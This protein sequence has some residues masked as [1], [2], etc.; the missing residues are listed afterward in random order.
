MA[1]RIGQSAEAD[2]YRPGGDRYRGPIF[3]QQ[4]QPQ[5]YTSIP[6]GGFMGQ[7]QIGGQ[8]SINVFRKPPSPEE[9][10]DQEFRDRAEKYQQ[11]EAEFNLGQREAD[12]EELNRDRRI[13]EG[14][15]RN[16]AH[17]IKNRYY[18]L[19]GEPVSA[20]EMKA[21]SGKYLREYTTP[22]KVTPEQERTNSI[23]KSLRQFQ[24]NP[25]Q[26]LLGGG[27]NVRELLNYLNTANQLFK[28][29]GQEGNFMDSLFGSLQKSQGNVPR[30][31][32]QN[33]NDVR[34][35]QRQDLLRR[36]EEKRKSRSYQPSDYRTYLTP[37][38]IRDAPPK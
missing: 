20:E 24:Q 36:E 32:L 13:Q 11:E 26:F 37:F 25:M 9:L 4:Q 16:A 10:E 31:S 8:S 12:L 6:T 33:K 17:Q 35:D 21:A 3:G 23:R 29:T 5:L 19:D 1:I 15:D 2:R 27:Q 14:K 30:Q 38:I 28:A 7:N 34:A 18:M 22:P